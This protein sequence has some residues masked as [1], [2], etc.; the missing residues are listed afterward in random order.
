[1]LQFN[2]LHDCNF[3]SISFL[4]CEVL[5]CRG[6]NY[7]VCYVIHYHTFYSL[8]VI[9]LLS[10][11]M[12]FLWQSSSVFVTKS[13]LFLHAPHYC[14]WQWWMKELIKQVFWFL[15]WSCCHLQ[16]Q[17]LQSYWTDTVIYSFKYIWHWDDFQRHGYV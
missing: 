5:Y 17:S 11:Y 12:L 4:S 10:P 8:N 1:M 9:L 3:S 7:D 13:K 2:L 14:P 6:L 15:Q 16:I